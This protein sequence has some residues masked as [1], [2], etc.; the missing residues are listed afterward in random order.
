MSRLKVLLVGGGGREHALAW[1]LSQSR[2]L[3]ELLIA[4]G[5]PGTA[6]LG[7]N[8]PVG[9][10]NVAE[11]VALAVR[12]RVDLVVVG[13][14]VPLALGIADALHH[15]GIACFGPMQAAATIESSKAFAKA[16][17]VAAGIP[18]AGHRVFASPAAALQFIDE[19]DWAAW[20]V[21][22]ADGL[23]AGKG[24]VVAESLAELRA[25]IERLGAGGDPVVLEEPLDGV[26]V[27]LL[28]FSDGRT[29]A[30]MLPAQ[31]H[32]RLHEGDQGPN[33]GGMGAYAPVPGINAAAG[34]ELRRRMIEPAI[35]ALAER[36][37]PFVGVLF[38]NLMLTP[39][40]P[41]VLEYNA[42]WGDPET[43]ALLPL[44]DADLL[45]IMEACVAG[46]LAPETVRWRAGAA[47][48]VVLA[49]ANYPQSP[50]RGDRIMLPSA[51]DGVH[52]FHAGTALE[53]GTL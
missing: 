37:S 20:R 30:A 28:A 51:P 46:R 35:G 47:L 41:R 45:E 9:A 33:T 15:A 24:V 17:M 49:A 27:S 5:N 23:H 32:K 6:G 7:R 40:G 2:R 52:I 43:Q 34:E 11:L 4:P 19:E 22:K 14:E 21:V 42:R 44:L 53:D 29:C 48:G 3:H 12:E 18:T 13:P 8:V 25:A 16:L 1:K 10:E 26:E 38:A 39:A 31:D 36:G 50:R